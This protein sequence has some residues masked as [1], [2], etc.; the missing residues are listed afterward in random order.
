MKIGAIILS[1]LSSSRLPGKALLK[2][3][4]QPLIQYVI[5][6]CKH[7]EGISN[8]VL[9]TSIEKSDDPLVGYAEENGLDYY[10]GELDNV[11]LR[12][13][14]TMK[15]YGFDAALR[16]NGDSPLNAPALLEQGIGLYKKHNYDLVTNVQKRT[17]PYGMSVE[18][19]GVDAM[20]L[21]YSMMSEKSHFEHV[22]QFFYQNEDYFKI[23]NIESGREDY[24]NVR[25][26]VDTIDDFT[27]FKWIISQARE[28]I[29]S[30]S[31]DDL[32]NLAS[33][34]ESAI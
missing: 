24:Q 6:L 18:V 27:R 3:D 11:A 21:A 20:S 14:L 26:A 2:V 13:L 28:D 1:R 8:I 10:R 19:V 25:M 31:Y 17:F 4:G 15:E 9:A 7:T 32:I 22:T 34:F 5:N 33:R 30:Y 23:Y 29:L 12:F 16:V